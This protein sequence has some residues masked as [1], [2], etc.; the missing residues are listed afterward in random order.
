MVEIET[1]SGERS[2]K[3]FYDDEE[4]ETTRRTAEKDSQCLPFGRRDGDGLENW[5]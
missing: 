3:E 4:N 2:I 5:N 1:E